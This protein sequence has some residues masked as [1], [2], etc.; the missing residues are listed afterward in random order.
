M[1]KILLINRLNPQDYSGDKVK[2]FFLIG[3]MN[4][5]SVENRLIDLLNKLGIDTAKNAILK[6][7]GVELDINVQ[8][9]PSIVNILS[10]EKIAIYGIYQPYNPDL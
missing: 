4:L 6:Y 8:Q 7:N 3:G 9:I 5:P 10:S 2:V 1:N